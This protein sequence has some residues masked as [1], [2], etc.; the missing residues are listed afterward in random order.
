MEKHPA[1]PGAWN[2]FTRTSLRNAAILTLALLA[3][4]AWYAYAQE[5]SL[6]DF[7]SRAGYTI[8]VGIVLSLL[9]SLGHWLSPL[10]VDSGPRGIVRSKG[11]ALALIPWASIRAYQFREIEG[12][13]VLE[14]V[15]SYSADPERLYLPRTVDVSAIEQELQTHLTAV[16]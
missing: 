3:I 9:F 13:L 5:A 16:A 14:L 1:P 10:E 11:D 15:V 7:V 2:P 4:G 6:A 12:E 8:A